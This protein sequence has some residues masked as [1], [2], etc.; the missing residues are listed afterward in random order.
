KT[1]GNILSYARIMAI[2]TA[3]VVMAVVANKLGGAVGNVLL[4]IIVA[5]LI[6]TLN[7]ALGILS[8]TI[9]SLR[10]HYVEFF[11]KFYQPGGRRYT[12]F[13]KSRE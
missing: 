8:P 7:V 3:S 9:H 11:S 2:G 4:G 6:H 12:P 5:A 1:V 13:K 10:L